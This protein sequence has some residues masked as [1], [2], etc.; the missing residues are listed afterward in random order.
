MVGAARPEVLSQ[1]KLRPTKPGQAGVSVQLKP[2][3]RLPSVARDG[4]AGRIATRLTAPLEALDGEGKTNARSTN[5]GGGAA[6]LD[7][8]VVTIYLH[9]HYI[10]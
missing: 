10:Y 3:P 5:L 4:D 7:I 2:I 6:A 1:L 8:P 9:S